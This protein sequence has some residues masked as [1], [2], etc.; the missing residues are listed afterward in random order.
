MKPYYIVRIYFSLGLVIMRGKLYIYITE[1]VSYLRCPY[2]C[3]TYNETAEAIARGDKEIRT[4]QLAFMS[5]LFIKAGW[6]IIIVEDKYEYVF[7][8]EWV[9][10]FPPMDFYAMFN[11]WK[12][13]EL[14][15]KPE[16]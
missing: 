2:I 1:P 11:C 4:F 13:G 3:C 7:T 15:T 5:H 6:D 8:E 9:N 16:E 10:K 14:Y 12:A